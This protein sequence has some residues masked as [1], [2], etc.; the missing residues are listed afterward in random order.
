MQ[1]NKLQGWV[2]AYGDLVLEDNCEVVEAVPVRC[3][4][5]CIRASLRSSSQMLEPTY[6]LQWVR[7]RDDLAISPFFEIGVLPG[8][9][10][11]IEN[12][13]EKNSLGY[14]FMVSQAIFSVLEPGMAAWQPTVCRE[15]Q[16]RVWLGKGD[17][18]DQETFSLDH[19]MMR[20]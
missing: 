5:S 16:L 1:L 18:F 8:L 14:L 4:I 9:V 3:S 6:S 17:S 13:E 12:L 15:P 20:H 2:I 11:G 10:T 7:L 19:L